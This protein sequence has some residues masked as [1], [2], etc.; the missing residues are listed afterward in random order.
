MMPERTVEVKR[1]RV[2]SGG[3]WMLERMTVEDGENGEISGGRRK[4]KVRDRVMSG[5]ERMLERR[6]VE[7]G[8][9]G[10]ISEGM[11]ER[12]RVEDG[13]NGVISGGW[14]DE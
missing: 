3:E 9:D 14:R 12:R 1:E 6:R 2:I 11:L 10:E 4:W 5:G 8:E 13:E 7:D